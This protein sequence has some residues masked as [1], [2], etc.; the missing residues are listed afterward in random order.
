[1]RGYNF[2]EK[3]HEEST[4]NVYDL[5]TKLFEMSEQEYENE[6]QWTYEAAQEYSINPL[7]ERFIEICSSVSKGT[8]PNGF[9]SFLYYIYIALLAIKTLLKNTKAIGKP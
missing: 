7:M 5:I 3:L 4:K 9:P 8:N 1:M 2:G 6:M